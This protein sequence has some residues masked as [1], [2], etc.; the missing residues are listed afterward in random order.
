MDPDPLPRQELGIHPADGRKESKPILID[1]G[2]HEPNLIAMTAQ[3][4]DRFGLQP[5]YITEGISQHVSPHFIDAALDVIPEN[6]LS[7]LFITGGTGRLGKGFQKF[8]GFGSHFSSWVDEAF[9]RQN[10]FFSLLKY[11]ILQSL[12]KSLLRV[13]D[14]IP[15]QEAKMAIQELPPPFFLPCPFCAICVIWG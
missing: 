9:L 5:S 8:K 6:F 2:D 10:Y 15:G 11:L 12:F 4:H 1:I 3:H 14:H 7:R 13:S